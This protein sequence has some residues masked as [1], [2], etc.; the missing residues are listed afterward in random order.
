MDPQTQV[1]ACLLTNAAYADALCRRLF[2]EIF[3]EYA[4]IEMP[5]G[6]APAAGPVDVDPHR[7]AGR[8]ERTARRL[9]VFVSDG[10]LNMT[11]TTTGDLAAFSDGP[12]DVV[13]Y[14]ADASGDNFVCRSHDDEPWTSV[15]FGQL[16]DREPY[17]SLGGR[18][19]PRTR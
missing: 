4:R 3:G 14:P 18:V 7:H 5:P 12:E 13:L 11:I 10:Q 1:I 2:S 16:S 15:T 6:S 19:T 9:D 8:Y 17:L